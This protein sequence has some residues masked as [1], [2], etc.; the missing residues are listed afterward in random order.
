MERTLERYRATAVAVA[1]TDGPRGLALLD[2]LDLEAVYLYEKHPN[3]FRRLRDALNDTAAAEGFASLARI[4]RIEA[5][6]TSIA[7]A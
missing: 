3:D 6:M 7:V 5:P 4:L 1:Q 2:A